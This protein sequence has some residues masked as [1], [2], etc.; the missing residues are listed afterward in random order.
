VTG[1]SKEEL[2]DFI[3]ELKAQLAEAEGFME[4]NDLFD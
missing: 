1:L 3:G 4:R 2:Q